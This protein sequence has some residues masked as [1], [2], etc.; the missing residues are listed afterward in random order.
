MRMHLSIT[1]VIILSGKN[2]FSL[3]IICCMHKPHYPAHSLGVFRLGLVICHYEWRCRQEQLLC[4]KGDFSV[5]EYVLRLDFQERNDHIKGDEHF[6]DWS[7]VPFPKDLCCLPP[8]RSIWKCPLPYLS[9][10][11]CW[12]ISIKKDICLFWRETV[13]T[14]CCW[15]HV[16]SLIAGEAGGFSCEVCH[17]FVFCLWKR[18]VPH[19]SVQA[20]LIFLAAL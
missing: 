4:I 3:C 6:T 15:F 2:N 12:E 11:H 9:P 14:P 17:L 13:V 7:C 16:Y 20:L 19:L 18:S 10:F 8:T 1:C 5:L